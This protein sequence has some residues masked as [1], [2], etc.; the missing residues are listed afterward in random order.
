MALDPALALTPEDLQAATR[1]EL[2]EYIGN[3]NDAAKRMSS[4]HLA[5]PMRHAQ[6]NA[7]ISEVERRDAMRILTAP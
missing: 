2:L 6:L 3:I 4:H 1:S 5:Y 7:A